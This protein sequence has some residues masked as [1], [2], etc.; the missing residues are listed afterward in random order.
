M[1]LNDS[2]LN[3]LIVSKYKASSIVLFLIVASLLVGCNNDDALPVYS[4]YVDIDPAG[5]NRLDNVEFEIMH[6]DSTPIV[7][8]GYDIMLN[9]RHTSSYRYRNLALAIETVDVEGV[10]TVDTISIPI[11][12][13]A[14]KWEGRGSYGIYE[15]S[16][17]LKKDVS[18]PEGYTISVSPAMNENPL[19]GIVNTGI[20]VSKR[21]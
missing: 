17:I 7:G 16:T 1:T 2:L 3:R 20:I 8:N 10:Q 5:W 21:K 6:R 19:T 13:S 18:I 4:C 15:T 12:N 11:S 14:G 9:V